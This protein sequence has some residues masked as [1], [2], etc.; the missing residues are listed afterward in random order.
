MAQEAVNAI[1][2]AF[3]RGMEQVQQVKESERR[4]QEFAQEQKLRE[5]QFKAQ[6]EASDRLYDLQQA[7]FEANRAQ[8]QYQNLQTF[9]KTGVV[10]PGAVLTPGLPSSTL[11]T[12][13]PVTPSQIPVGGAGGT[14]TG[15][16]PSPQGPLTQTGLGLENALLT[17]P[18]GGM[19]QS[20]PPLEMSPEAQ[21]AK[22]QQAQQLANDISKEQ[23]LAPIRAQAELNARIALEDYTYPKDMARLKQ[24][25]DWDMAK[26]QMITDA[27][28]ADNALTNST[29]LKIATMNR[30]LVMGSGGALGIDADGNVI[31]GAGNTND[32]L[33][34]R[35]RGVVNGTITLEDLSKI[36]PNAKARQA[37][38]N[39][40]PPGVT[41][42]NNKQRDQLADYQKAAAFI[43]QLDIMYKELNE[44]PSSIASPFPNP[45]KTAFEN[46]RDIVQ[47]NRAQFV[48]I[49]EGSNRYTHQQA[50]DVVTGVIPSADILKVLG[51][52]ILGSNAIAGQN[53]K[54][55][56][57][58][59]H[60]IQDPVNQIIGDKPSS[61]QLAIR[62]RIG[63][64][65]LREAMTEPGVEHPPVIGTTAP[66]VNPSEERIHVYDNK[67][68]Q[69]GYQLKK[70]IDANPSRYKILGPGR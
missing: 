67:N 51:D 50:E 14:G 66:T 23:A 24:V 68:K 41:P 36:Y 39:T 10:P 58:V 60:Q 1:V 56:F 9:Q 18:G 65:N 31:Q 22:T 33:I 26:E 52:K 34:Q 6:K 25:H 11:G 7:Q 43:P 59:R 30:D 13:A 69:E 47:G 64:P 28:R 2:Q 62:N 15:I 54:Y 19:P 27:Q 20:V 61:V 12:R 46:A 53:A 8:N 42:L 5:D 3:Q 37:F 49:L 40:L 48:R 45:D 29:R 55:D 35:A 4:A 63:L 16:V 21:L 32:Q 44:H 70:Y 57:F 17:Y 38:M